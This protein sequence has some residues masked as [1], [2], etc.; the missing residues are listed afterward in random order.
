[1]ATLLAAGFLNLGLALDFE[2]ILSLK[3]LDLT[4]SNFLASG[5][6]LS[7][8]IGNFFSVQEI[9]TPGNYFFGELDLSLAILDD[10]MIFE[11]GRIFASDVFAESPLWDYYLSAGINDNP[12]AIPANIFFPGFNIAAWAVRATYQPNEEWSLIAGMYNADTEVKE[13][14]KHGADF[15]FDMDNGFLAIAQLAYEHDQNRDDKGHPGS[16]TFGGY[17]QSSEFQDLANPAQYWDGNCGFYLIFDQMIFRG[18]WPE[19]MGP[20]YLRSDATDAERIAH[21]YNRQPVIPLD[22]PKGLTAWGMAYLAPLKRI[23]TQTYQLAA[24]LLYKG[25]PPNRDYDVTAFC[26]ILGN[27]SDQL[28]GQGIE[29]VL[30]LNHRFQI[31]QWFYIT[32]DIQYIINPDGRPSIDDALALGFELGVRF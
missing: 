4:V 15:S 32:P 11:V 2:K 16:T 7:G 20:S 23:N 10:T 14:D 3:G 24:G 12:G 22:R 5:R 31:G 29:M 6:N 19:F 1:M 26:F 9:Y 13:P 17:Y 30:E 28:E 8:E 18:D 25:L 27:F 21:P